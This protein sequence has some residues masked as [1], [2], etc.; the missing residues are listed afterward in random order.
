MNFSQINIARHP[1]P[2]QDWEDA[3]IWEPPLSPLTTP[4]PDGSQ[5]GLVLTVFQFCI[6]RPIEYTFFF[7]WLILVNIVGEESSTL[8]GIIACCSFSLVSSIP[9]CVWIYRVFPYQNTVG[10]HFGWFILQGYYKQC[11]SHCPKCLPVNVYGNFFWVYTSI[12]QRN[13]RIIRQAYVQ[14]CGILLSS[15]KKWSY[16][17]ICSLRVKDILTT[18]IFCLFKNMWSFWQI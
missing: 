5:N 10:G 3:R 18:N 4:K 14:F 7:V 13:C 8:L 6:N 9:L 12:Q 2:L 1:C 16:Q 17:F 15:F 11:Y